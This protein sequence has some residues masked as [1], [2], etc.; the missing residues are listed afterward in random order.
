MKNLI[1]AAYAYNS[2]F[3]TSANMIS[4]ES[5]KQIAIYLQNAFVCLRNAKINNPS[6]DVALFTNIDI[7]DKYRILFVNN[8]ILIRKIEFD[9][10]KFSG[11][12][13]WGLAFFKLC[14]LW[15]SVYDFDYENIAMLD[16]DTYTINSFSDIWKEAK[17]QILLY[18]IFHWYSNKNEQIMRSE[19]KE[20][21]GLDNVTHY[22]GE[23][24]C[25]NRELLKKYLSVCLEQANIM[26]KSN[27]YTTRGDEYLV[28]ISAH[29]LKSITKTANAYVQ[30]CWTGGEYYYC[31]TYMWC[32][33]VSV[34]H[35]PNEKNRG[36]IQLFRYYIK[37]NKFPK[38][39]KTFKIL[40]LPTP[41][42]N[43]IT[44]VKEKLKRMF[45]FFK[46][47]K[48]YID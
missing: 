31:S 43:K 14:A 4:Y 48:Y 26:V 5:K 12:V 24:I 13:K 1:F 44:R 25:S 40:R 22:G 37:H 18:D 45:G 7:P 21:A 3:Q 2:D 42:N 16:L 34:I 11:D 36:M 6:D 8:H 17:T 28:S 41:K 38:N 20:I 35:I 46:C 10:F 39:N 27:H 33:P 29:K 32:T 9:H 15:H 23:F 30:R 47:K 19:I